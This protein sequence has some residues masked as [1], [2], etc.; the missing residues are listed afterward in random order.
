MS[1]P[2]VL[3][4][5]TSERV[6]FEIRSHTP[7]PEKEGD[8]PVEVYDWFAVSKPGDRLCAVVSALDF[9]ELRRLR[10]IDDIHARNDEVFKAARVEAFYKGRPIGGQ[11]KIPD[12]HHYS[13][14]AKIVALS[15]VGSDPF[16]EAPAA[17]PL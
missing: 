14:I 7:K 5:L 10:G 4:I 3:P 8:E 9:L 16:A 11:E 15:S 2:E 12:A 13:L 1:L 6:T 17:S